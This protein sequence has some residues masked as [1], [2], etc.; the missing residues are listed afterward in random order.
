MPGRHAIAAMLA[1]IENLLAGLQAQQ[2]TPTDLVLQIEKSFRAHFFLNLHRGA[3][4]DAGEGFAQ[5]FG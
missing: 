1:A 5:L 2:I 4:R 3:G